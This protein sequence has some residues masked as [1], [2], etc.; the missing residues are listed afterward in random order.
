MPVVLL[1]EISSLKTKMNALGSFKN[2]EKKALQAQID[3]MNTEALE[4]RDRVNAQNAEREDELSKLKIRLREVDA[5][6]KRQ[7]S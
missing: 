4:L 3:Q 7:Q 1:Y 5:L 2:K 6:L